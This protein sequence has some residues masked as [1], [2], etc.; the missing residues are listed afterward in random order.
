[1]KK[2]VTP[3]LDITVIQIKASRQTVLPTSPRSRSV[4]ITSVLSKLI[5]LS[6]FGWHTE[7]TDPA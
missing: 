4:E 5:H 2:D 3:A 6:A 7:K 1:M